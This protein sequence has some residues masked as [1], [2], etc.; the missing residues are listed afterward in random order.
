VKRIYLSREFGLFIFT[1][2]S[3]A[4]VNFTSR[5]IYNQWMGFQAAVIA[6]YLTGMVT[7]FILAKRFVF[8]ASTQQ[9][10]RSIIFFCLV[11]LLAIM[12][13]WAIS[14][15]LAYWILPALGVKSYSREIAHAV[16]VAF[17]VFTSY[18]GHKRFSFR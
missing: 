1:G 15:G 10:H 2:G 18:I 7:A 13:T 16:G 6:A 3:A 5:I 9:I 4:V 8:K 14:V 11:N 12:Q 17:P